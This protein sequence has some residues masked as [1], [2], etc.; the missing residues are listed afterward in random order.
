MR[1]SS[2][3]SHDDSH[4][5]PIRLGISTCLLG[6]NVRY[7]GGHRRNGFLADVLGPLVHWVP[8]CPEVEAGMGVPREAVRL[9][10]QDDQLRMISVKTQV[11]HT[12]NMTRYARRRA[13]ELSAEG[14]CGYVL[15]KN[16]PSCG[17]QRVKVY[18]PRGTSHDG[19]GLF[20]EALIHGQPLLPVEDEGRL[21]DPGL[22]E[23]FVERVFAYHRLRRLFQPRWRLGDLVDFHTAHKLQ[24]LS[25]GQVAYRALGRLVAAAKASP[26]RDLRDQYEEQFMQTLCRQATTR[27]HVN[28]LQHIAGYFKRDLDSASRREL[29]E[30]IEDYRQSLVPLIVPVTLIRHFI[31]RLE[32]DYLAGQTYLNPH[33]KELMLRNH[34]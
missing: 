30:L 18:H 31:R 16:S 19:R 26:R 11:D 34:V 5:E 29:A 23:N 17:M 21:N 8:V 24:L 32:I 27:R 14:L 2:H 6:E 3:G 20:A 12:A 4:E 9:V 7:D 10:R 33:P 28:V 15:K 22:R 1:E 25:H 13:R